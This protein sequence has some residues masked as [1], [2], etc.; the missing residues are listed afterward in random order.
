MP[1][2]QLPSRPQLD[3][4]KQQAK[5]LARNRL[6][7]DIESKQRIRE[8]HPKFKSASDEAIRSSP[9]RLSDAQLTIAREYGFASWPRLKANVEEQDR[10]WQAL[11]LHDQIEDPEFREAVDLIDNGDI[12]RLNALIRNHPDLVARR[13]SF[14][15]RN[16]FRNPSLLQFTAENPIR[17]GALPR[18][19]L[20]VVSLLLEIGANRDLNDVNET[21]GL[22]CSGRIVR[23]AGVQLQIID[24][25]LQHGANPESALRLAVAH[26]EWGAAEH[27][28]ATKAILDLPVAAALGQLPEVIERFSDASIEDRHLALAWASQY[29]HST[30]VEWL[31]KAGEDPNRYNPVGAHSHSTPLHQAAFAGHLDAVKSL[32][33][34][35]ARFDIP[36]VLWKGT[37]MNWAEHGNRSE[38]VAYLKSLIGG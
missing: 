18:N 14:E 5:D 28:L 29:G 23:E 37:A 13:V 11:P 17:Q 25:L 10:E 33:R 36:D 9:F 16:Y 2:K 34:H 35:G 27:L 31:L 3:R 7:E 30:T 12:G 4:L 19:I 15:G 1:V 24:V 8:F 32:V 20:E 6:T 22:V 21:L 26:E 38:V